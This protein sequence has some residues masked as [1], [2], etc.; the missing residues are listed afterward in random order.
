MIIAGNSHVSM[1]RQN[2]IIL[3]SKDN[4]ISINWVGALTI[5]HFF[6]KHP[7]AQKIR[8]IFANTDSWKFLSIG[9]HDYNILIEAFANNQYENILNILIKKY[10]SVFF[11][12][13]S[14]GKFG[15]LIAPQ[16]RK[17]FNSHGLS[18]K[19]I[20][21]CSQ[22]LN[23]ILS[24]W[25]GKNNIIVLN[26]LINLIKENGCTK[27]EFLK[28]DG[29]HLNFRAA[30]YYIKEIEYK[31]GEKLI[32]EANI[33]STE[34]ILEPKTGPESLA[35]LIAEELELPW[36]Q[37][38]FPPGTRSKFEN[39][40]ILYIT[41]RLR[42][43]NIDSSINRS[44]DYIAIGKFN[45]LELV[46]IYTYVTELFGTDINF[47]LYIRDLNTVEKLSAFFLNNKSL[48]KNDFFESLTPDSID[49]IRNSEIIFADFR[50][51][52]MNENMYNNLKDII[53]IQTGGNNFGYGIIFF[54]FAIIEANNGN[55]DVALN[56]LNFVED[57]RLAFPFESKRL[58]FY[59]T[60]WKKKHT[61]FEVLYTD[62]KGKKMNHQS[63][64]I[65]VLKKQPNIA[66][67]SI[68]TEI[69]NI[70]KSLYNHAETLLK[71]GNLEDAIDAFTRTI[72]IC[73][74]CAMA[75]FKQGM[76]LW[77][78]NQNQEALKY[79]NKALSLDP[80]NK[81]IVLSF[82]EFC[83]IYNMYSDAKTIYSLY[84]QKN[85]D[86]KEIYNLLH[87]PIKKLNTVDQLNK[88]GEIIYSAGNVQ[89]AFNAFSEA[90]KVNPQFSLTYNNLGV[91]FYEKGDLEKA[92]NLFLEALKLNPD[93][94][95]ARENYNK[96]LHNKI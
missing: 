7:A 50:I 12:L 82:A 96:L 23:N 89:G 87:A 77:G 38:N 54:W 17:N 70:I 34:N 9:L 51:A 31:T 37:T 43:K 33:Q 26:P 13:N 65:N 1:F 71:Q 57:K 79:F 21:K 88:K 4:R 45:S 81:T 76:I 72:Q 93:D 66:D 29:I 6:K 64:P 35:L 67:P 69:D 83:N 61:G 24:A 55:F 56:L 86:D 60:C 28:T 40:I 90:I 27:D 85:P 36:D 44:S 41:N 10:Q 14:K 11:E 19:N 73:P 22:D 2:K 48:S 58:H 84:L 47:D 3:E 94:A 52:K 8:S 30:Q 63:I 32:V 78:Q 5:N 46:E 25:C 74:D 80:S 68:D 92:A 91:L 18:E 53:Y 62:I 39:Q 49:D 20:I 42:K 75:Y 16:Q 59:K 15:W 95:N